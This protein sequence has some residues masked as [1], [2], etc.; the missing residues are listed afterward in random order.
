MADIA[1]LKASLGD[2]PLVTD[3]AKVQLR[4][5]DFYWYSPVLK[6]QL[7]GVR[8]DLVVEPR[9]EAE[10]VRALAACHGA[11]VPVT[12]RGGGTGNYGQ[13]MPLAGGVVLDLSRL[14]K[15]R[16]IAA[17]RVRA[18]AGAKLARIDQLCQADCGQELR[19]HPSTL[20]MGT[21]GGFVA[22]GSSGVGS[23][24][25]G[26]LR[27]RGNILGLRVITMEDAPRTIEL[28]GDAIQ[29]VNHAYGTN[30]VIT[31]VEMPLAPAYPWVDLIVGFDD[32]MTAARFGDALARQDG[33]VKKLVTALAAPIAELY[34]RPLQGRIPAG[35][36]VVLLM[37]AEPSMQ[38]FRDFL[39]LWPGKILL[40]R[41]A[42]DPKRRSL[43]VYELSWNHT[44][45]HALRIDPGVTYLQVLY[46]PPAPSRAG[47]AHASPV[48]RRGMTHLEF[49]RFE[50]E[51]ACFG[52]PIV[53]FSSEERLDEII[54]QPRGRRLPD[55]QS[56]RLH[57]G[58]GRHEAGRPQPAR[59]QA[60]GRP[61]GAA[62]PGQDAGLGQPG[63]RDERALL[64]L[65]F[66]RGLSPASAQGDRR[67][68]RRNGREPEVSH[69][70]GA[71]RAAQP[72]LPPLGYF[73]AVNQNRFRRKAAR[74]ANPWR[75][76]VSIYR[77]SHSTQ[78]R[79]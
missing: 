18:E 71:T 14:D 52:L 37:I 28:R 9:D 59:V 58:G 76:L 30:G 23:I 73:G 67:A 57:A 19:F 50:G 56:A 54:R 69:A 38:A 16:E 21:I 36:S 44:T 40:E 66:S 64:P 74:G 13:A 47:R 41:K 75:T 45:L 7:E 33:L 70:L 32:F 5:R 48:R 43:P 12:V 63:A 49:V 15:V 2:I 42:S 6:R 60:R 35:S 4:S 31:E 20:K 77:R 51:V 29:K 61:A 22:G 34:F 8:A 62:Q 46:P 72:L 11:R 27:D 24:T 65:P 3:P 68:R 17:G 26:I 53:R 79:H 78:Y 1:G 25:W 55:L 10:V 39:G